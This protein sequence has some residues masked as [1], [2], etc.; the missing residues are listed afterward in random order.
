[1]YVHYVPNPLL[2]ADNVISE[3]MARWIDEFQQY[4]LIIKYQPGSQVNN[5]L[6]EVKKRDIIHCIME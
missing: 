6:A 4:T 5:Y 1:M 2:V 3:Q